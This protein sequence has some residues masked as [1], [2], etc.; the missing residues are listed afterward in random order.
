MLKKFLYISTLLLCAITVVSCCKKNDEPPYNGGKD[1]KHT[2]LVYMMAKNSLGNPLDFDTENINAMRAAFE[3]NNID[4][5][6]L[7]VFLS[8][9]D[10]EP[11]LL[12]IK[13]DKNHK[14][15]V[16]T[17]KWYDGCIST[18]TATMNMVLRDVHEISPQGTY[19]LIVWSHAN[20]WLP[21][22][23]FY[24]MSYS[25]APASI[26]HEGKAKSTMDI[27]MFAKALEPYHFDYVLFDA[28]L[29]GCVEVA[30]ELRNVCD[31]MIAT[32]T[33]TMGAGFPY[34]RIIPL[35]YADNKDLEQVCVEY[36]NEYIAVGNS[37]TI[38]LVE[39]KNIEFLA[40]ACRSIAVGREKK[41]AAA[42]SLAIQ[43]FDR[44]LPHIFFDLGHFMEYLANDYQYADF[45]VAL[46]L[47]VPYRA[48][49]DRFLNIRIN[50]Y[51]GL[52]SYIPGICADETVEE[53]YHTLQWYNRVYKK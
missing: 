48:S 51:S 4:D 15:V 11:C 24:N 18:D 5:G 40:E 36:Y 27:D 39:M 42:N 44:R 10:Q 34:R 35:L 25:A 38:S 29:M 6:R 13:C 46:D 19:G 21:Q 2:I 47:A 22:Y 12:E 50:H 43:S 52:S 3:D 14:S 17:L 33:E 53:Y 9:Y 45:L 16:D 31:Y 41:I 37:G 8:E 32:P 1:I 28:C 7:L 30:Y 20:G 49:G 23:H 26:G